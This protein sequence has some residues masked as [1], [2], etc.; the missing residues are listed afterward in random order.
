MA[1][2]LFI[3]LFFSFSHL[4]LLQGRSIEKYHMIDVTYHGHMSEYHKGH[5]I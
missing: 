1:K 3:F 4:D 5:I 2:S